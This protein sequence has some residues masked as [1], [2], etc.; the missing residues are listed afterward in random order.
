[1]LLDG[2]FS[3]N[4][5][6]LV[7][8]APD[9]EAKTFTLTPPQLPTDHRD[10]SYCFADGLN[11]EKSFS[12]ILDDTSPFVDQSNRSIEVLERTRKTVI[13]S[14]VSTG[15]KLELLDRNIV[16]QIKSRRQALDKALELT[17]C[18]GVVKRTSTPDPD[19]QCPTEDCLGGG[20][21]TNTSQ[22]PWPLLPEDY[23]LPLRSFFDS[24]DNP[25]ALP[26]RSPAI[27]TP[28]ICRGPGVPWSPIPK[29]QQAESRS[30][31]EEI[32][33]PVILAEFDPIQSTCTQNRMSIADAKS[34][35][36]QAEKRFNTLTSRYA[37]A[38]YN[39]TVVSRCQDEWIE[40]ISVA[41][42]GLSVAVD[43]LATFNDSLGDNEL[44][45]WNTKISNGEAV[46]TSLIN[47]YDNKAAAADVPVAGINPVESSVVC[48]PPQRGVDNT[49]ARK[50]QVDIDVDAK[51]IEEEVKSLE[52][53]VST[54]TDWEDAENSVVEEY[55]GKITEWKKTIKSLKEK[56]YS[57]ER[58]TK[59]HKFDDTKMKTSAALIATVECK[60]NT[61][62]KSIK[63]EDSSRCLYSM[64]KSTA[65]K[66]KL[67]S[68][69]G[70]P[71]EDFSTFMEEVKKAF[72]A[73]KVRKDDQ[74]SKLKEC[75]KS[76]ARKL[77]P[78]SMKEI[79]NCWDTLKAVYGDPSRVM[80]AK[81]KKLSQMGR[82]PADELNNPTSSYLRQQMEWLLSL[83]VTIKEIMFWPRMMMRWKEKPME[84]LL[85]LPLTK[86]FHFQFR[87]NLPRLE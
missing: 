11:V 20:F 79:D 76:H 58:N 61:A 13:A 28:V 77:I 60:V 62:I 3:H 18:V 39:S 45:E 4:I 19:K 16:K 52:V 81:K 35:C 5:S 72:V 31:L 64:C 6:K 27:K 65:A 68:F 32:S 2:G 26:I 22:K 85:S 86:C 73:N 50:A 46:L 34:N 37:P 40:K 49:A 56:S 17:N 29:G 51:I 83:E 42:D 69:S 43:G 75:L 23:Q 48:R 87:R 30:S 80:N 74:P 14:G 12:T 15:K 53:E 41:L 54:V 25:Q 10:R 71:E 24:I 67:P 1:M 47:Q 78:E 55:M 36:V 38:K 8:Q 66:V 59:F 63:D 7:G 21:G 44:Q 82:Y 84:V 9:Q 57:M 33:L 70:A